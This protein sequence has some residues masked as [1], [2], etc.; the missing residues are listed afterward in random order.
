MK[1]TIETKGAGELTAVIGVVSLTG[2]AG[3]STVVNNMLVPLMPGAKL[4]QMETINLSGITGASEEVRLKGREIGK[5][6]D[7]LQDTAS[8]IVDVGASNVESFLLALNQQSDAHLD[9]DFF[10]VPIEANSAK[11][12][13]MGEAIKTINTLADMGIEPIFSC[14]SMHFLK[15]KKR[16]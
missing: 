16:K 1:K 5:L 4:V 6:Q 15:Q 7:A 12:N 2:K 8:A 14:L 13:E 11:R 10:I 9:F 3:K